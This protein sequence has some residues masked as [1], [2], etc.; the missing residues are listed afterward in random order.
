MRILER[1]CIFGLLILVIGCGIS[2]EPVSAPAVMVNEP[3]TVSRSNE[4]LVHEPIVTEPGPDAQK[5]ETS[6]NRGDADADSTRDPMSAMFDCQKLIGCWKDT[7]C[8]QR[9]LTLK[10]DGSACMHLDLD[11]AGR[12][13][14]GK[15]LD[16]DMRWSVDGTVI[17]FEILTGRPVDAAKSAM[18]I[19]GESFEYRLVLVDGEQ[20]QARDSNDS[21]LYKMTRVKDTPKNDAS[22]ME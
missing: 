13:L 14:Y 12:L 17:T 10:E 9:T 20:L 18:K 2:A 7:F 1:V 6:S 19:W 5:Q 16:F 11:L 22:A 8:G 21:Y 15:S 3:E 4:D